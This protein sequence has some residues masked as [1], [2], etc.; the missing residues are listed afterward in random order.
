M[1]K[2][3]GFSLPE[4]VLA[5]FIFGFMSMSLATIYA[6]AN[7][8]M[9]QGYRSSIIKTNGDYAMKAIQNNLSVATRLDFPAYGSGGNALA[10]ATNV[11]QMNGCYPISQLDPAAWY[12]FCVTAD[13]VMP[14]VSD[15]YYHTGPINGGTGCMVANPTT[16]TGPYPAFCG[17]G[18]GGTV[19]LLMQYIV[20]P[21]VQADAQSQFIFSRSAA[22]GV[23]EVPVVRVRLHSFWDAGARGFGSTQRNVDFTLDSLVSSNRTQ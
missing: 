16:W 15:L 19:T 20:A 1:A 8:H 7:R 14:G 6:T 23:R 13:A 4:L 5:M 9:F 18:G 21:N 3:S 2:R 22:D 17:P 10:F 11:D 12:Y